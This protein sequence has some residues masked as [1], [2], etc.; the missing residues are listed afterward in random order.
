MN[1]QIM[2]AIRTYGF[3]LIE[4]MITLALVAILATAAAPMFG[5]LLKNNRLAAQNNTILAS[6]N[7]ARNESVSRGVNVRL[8]PVVAGTDWTAGWRVR[9]DGND[10]GDFADSAD[11][12]TRNFE[13][14]EASTLTSSVNNIVYTPDGQV[15]AAA[16]LTLVANDCTDNHKRVIDVKLSGLAAMD[17]ND[18]S[19]P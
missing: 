2:I 9:V 1:G 5:D 8:E 14:L 3:T 6:L 10:D 13:A 12:V 18:Q 7:Y 15:Q 19:C 4:L 17:P 11:I 16:T